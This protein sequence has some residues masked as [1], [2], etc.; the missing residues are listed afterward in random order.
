MQ[1]APTSSEEEGKGSGKRIMGGSNWEGT[2]I[3]M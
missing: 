2:A 1:R 3:E